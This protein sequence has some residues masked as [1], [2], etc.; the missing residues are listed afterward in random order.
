MVQAPAKVE[1]A[2]TKKDGTHTCVR[3][4]TVADLSAYMTKLRAKL[5]EAS[6]QSEDDF[7]TSLAS[8]HLYTDPP[9]RP[10]MVV[11]TA[12]TDNKKRSADEM[13]DSVRKKLRGSGADAVKSPEKT[14]HQ[15]EVPATATTTVSKPKQPAGVPT[16]AQPESTTVAPPAETIETATVAIE[17][18][19]ADSD[20]CSMQIQ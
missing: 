14:V 13:M 17:I 15:T 4:L 7:R 19:S 16:R 20:V 5:L 9:A 8:Q 18:I 11:P 12:T 10:S 6:K 2:I 1:D 3:A